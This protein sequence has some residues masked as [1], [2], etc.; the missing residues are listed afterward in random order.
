MTDLTIF[1]DYDRFIIAPKAQACLSMTTGIFEAYSMK[2]ARALLSEARAMS[3][4]E[5][6]A[7]LR[8][9]WTDGRFEA[10]CDAGKFGVAW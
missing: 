1:Q 7:S 2:E 9:F 3:A 4:Q 10:A 8:T 5:I 6:S